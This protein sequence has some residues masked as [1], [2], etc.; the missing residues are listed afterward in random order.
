VG[1]H[2]VAAGSDTD[3][4][5]VKSSSTSPAFKKKA[6]L[7][8]LTRTTVQLVFHSCHYTHEAINNIVV[9]GSQGAFRL[10][11]KVLGVP[12]QGFR[13][14]ILVLGGSVPFSCN[15]WGNH[16]PFRKVLAD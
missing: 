14:P 3:E 11:K 15:I 1:A 2:A 4:K 10:P 8:S 9:E 5:L 13:G 6:A 16:N 12:V 7:R